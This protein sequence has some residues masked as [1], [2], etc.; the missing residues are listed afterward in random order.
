MLPLHTISLFVA[1]KP[2]VL[3]RITLLFS[4]RGF[5]IESLVVSSAMDG[6]FSRMTIT[7]RGK[8]E[9][10]EQI[11]KQLSKLVDVVSAS[12]HDEKKSVSTEIAYIKLGKITVSD[13]NEILQLLTH[14]K[15][16]VA[17]MDSDTMI[18]QVA[19][20]SETIDKL[21][22]ILA[23]YDIIELV[24]SGKVAML[25]GKEVT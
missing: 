14:Y 15:A 19:A 23:P 6:A 18:I 17:D 7:A 25:K 24:R 16:D 5:N 9:D 12:E 2:G 1:N 10:L 22:T 20:D 4:R 11:I 21:I 8:N 13:R 3:L